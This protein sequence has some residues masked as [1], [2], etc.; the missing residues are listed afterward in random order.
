[1][2]RSRGDHIVIFDGPEALI[3][4]YANVAITAANELSLFG[5]IRSQ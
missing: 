3:G 5:E 4:E 1:M 2:G